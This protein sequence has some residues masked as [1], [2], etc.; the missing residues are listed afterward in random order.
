MDLL[1]K[2]LTDMYSRTSADATTE[3]DIRLAGSTEYSARTFLIPRICY[4]RDN[5]TKWPPAGCNI[6]NKHIQDTG[7]WKFTN[8]CKF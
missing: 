6:Q 5:Q 7:K 4:Y 8:D 2:T 3:A 1:F